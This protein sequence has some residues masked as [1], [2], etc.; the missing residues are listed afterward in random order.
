MNER[1]ERASQPRAWQPCSQHPSQ[2]FTLTHPYPHPSS[3][4]SHSVRRHLHRQAQFN[5]SLTHSPSPPPSHPFTGRR[6]LHRETE[7]PPGGPLPP[8][9]PRGRQLVA[10]PVLPR[11]RDARSHR[12]VHVRRVRAGAQARLRGGVRQV[13]HRGQV[14]VW[15]Q[16]GMA[17]RVAILVADLLHGRFYQCACIQHSQSHSM[18]SH[19]MPPITS[20]PPP[21]FPPSKGHLR[22]PSLERGRVLQ[23]D[24]YPRHGQG[25]HQG[26]EGGGAGFE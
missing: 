8:P 12:A 3:F 4:P 24:S 16:I 17:V 5:A 11:A 21:P 13:H 14:R 20:S 23:R 18:M 26:S 19:P 10:Q 1:W 25:S 15:S 6:H 22:Q 7:S 2:S 9:H